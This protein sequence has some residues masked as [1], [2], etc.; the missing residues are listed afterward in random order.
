META[1]DHLLSGLKG[2]WYWYRLGVSPTAEDMQFTGKIISEGSTL[3]F[4]AIVSL[5]S[6][7][8]SWASTPNEFPYSELGGLIISVKKG[9]IASNTFSSTLVLEL[10]SK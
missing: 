8:A 3:S 5:A 7:S 4:L 1:Y 2:N 6:L 10:L 9:I